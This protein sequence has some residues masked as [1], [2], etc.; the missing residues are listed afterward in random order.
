MKTIHVGNKAIGPNQPAFVIA[1]IG[2]N[3]QGDLAIAKQ[4]ILIAHQ[5]GADAVKFQKRTTHK[6]LT[7]A[8]LD[9]IYDSPN[10]FGRTYGEHR[11]ALEFNEEQYRELKQYA[12]R[13]GI[14]MLASVWDEDSADFI[15]QL[16]LP[17]FKV[18]S[19]DLI[20][21]PLLKHIA[22]KGRPI[23]LSTG[24]ATMEEIEQ[25]IRWLE[26]WNH[27]LIILYC[28]STYPA[29]FDE[30][31]LNLIGEY[32]QKFP[33]YPIGYSGHELGIAISTLAV[34]AGAKVI[35]RHFTLDRAM[36]GGDHAASLEPG[37]LAR[38]VRDVH[39]AEKV[40]GS[41]QPKSLLDSEKPIRE[42]LAKSVVAQVAIPQGETITAEMLTTK[43]PGSGLPPK[44]I[45]EL[46]GKQ[47]AVDIPEDTV[48][49][50]DM[51]KW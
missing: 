14:L 45:Y 37:G 3:H 41:T 4:M 42:K 48:I 32:Q 29:S 17:A 7:R 9:R 51:V 5:A 28:V 11:E 19:A 38:L 12:D 30:I 33:D 2:I 43:G 26:Q 31:N 39:L 8:G 20:N 18:A 44:Y 49:M 47:A 40:F 25:A 22:Q 15:D 23:I 36:K 24:M 34:A 27:D 10:A 50:R 21:L 16:D 1:E 13:V 46:P 6:I 35:E